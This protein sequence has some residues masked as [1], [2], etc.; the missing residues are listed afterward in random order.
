MGG[1]LMEMREMEGVVVGRWRM[2]SG[3]ETALACVFDV[4]GH[5]HHP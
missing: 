2:T 1:L 4:D 3:G 5:V